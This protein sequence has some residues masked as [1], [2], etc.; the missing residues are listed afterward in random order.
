MLK[1]EAISD[2]HH[3]SFILSGEL[4][5]E[6]VHQLEQRWRKTSSAGPIHVDVCDVKRI[7]DSGKALL[8][9]MFCEGVELVVDAHAHSHS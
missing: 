4:A 3:T 8:S 1:I 7:D 6:G 9:R 5:D 2:G